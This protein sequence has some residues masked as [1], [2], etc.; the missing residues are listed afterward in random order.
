MSDFDLDRLGDVW[1]QQ[2]DPAETERIRKA[3]ATVARRARL[4][5]VIDI[6]AALVISAVVI[7]IVVAN[8]RP[9]I[10]LI[11]AA[12]I[13]VLLGSNVRLRRLRQ[14]ELET[15]TGSTED[16]IDQSIRRIETTLRYRYFSLLA[17]GPGLRIG[18][19]L[20]AGA[21]GNRLAALFPPLGEIMRHR[22]LLEGIFDGVILIAALLAVRSIGRSR[23]ELGLLRAMREAF[24]R[25]RE[26]TG[27]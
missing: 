23:K 18:I 15:L 7:L 5:Q 24:R 13:L 19:I 3:A 14:V 9:G 21:G 4:A 11:G 27:P 25:E 2:P 6:G 16:M 10:V 20:G 12:A 22:Y 8:P 17:V 1:R 26:S